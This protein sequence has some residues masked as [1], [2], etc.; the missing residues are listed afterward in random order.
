M[1]GR[2]APVSI[3]YT[4]ILKVYLRAIATP[5]EMLPELQ[6]RFDAI[7]DRRRALFERLARVGDEDLRHHPS[8]TS[9]SLLQVVEHLV[10]VEGLIVKSMLRADQ[11]VIRRRWWHRIGAILVS[12]VL[13]R[14]FRVPAPSKKVVPLSNTPLHESGAKWD[15]LRRQLREFLERTT[16]DSAR[17]LGFRHP[18]SGPLDLPSSLDFVRAHFDHH[19]RQIA[20][21]EASIRRAATP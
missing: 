10:L 19:M 2:D 17:Q 9:W 3:S 20:R 1:L 5:L 11:P 7:E 8:P 12:I 14:G 16:P 4:V 13:T 6:E 15:E 18:V 21:I